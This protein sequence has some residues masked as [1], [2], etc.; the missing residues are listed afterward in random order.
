MHL[1]IWIDGAS[2]GNPGPGACAVVVKEP[3]GKVRQERR[4]FLGVVTNNVAEYISLLLALQEAKSFGAR[5]VSVKSD[6]ELLVR[7]INGQYRVKS[8]TLRVLHRRA[9]QLL[10]E[11]SNVEVT[12]IRRQENLDADNLV[13]Q[14]LDKFCRLEQ[15]RWPLRRPSGENRSGCGE[16]SPGSEGQGGR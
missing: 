15:A 10:S 11:F 5:T 7:Q 1:D 16:E 12:H 4:L 13:N 9:L 8:P 2:R 6:S 3:G 14:E